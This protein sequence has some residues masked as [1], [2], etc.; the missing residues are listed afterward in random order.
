M[1]VAGTEG[2]SSTPEFQYS[3]QGNVRAQPNGPVELMLDMK[4]VQQADATPAY[5]AKVGGQAG[6]ARDAG[7]E[8]TFVPAATVRL[9]T[10]NELNGQWRPV[11]STT[12]FVI[13]ASL[14]N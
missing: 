12:A 5:L 10:L 13:V 6:E 14:P 1:S 4:L 7:F 2:S 11:N 3:T 8:L 9:E